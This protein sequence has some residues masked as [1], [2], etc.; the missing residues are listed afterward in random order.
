MLRKLF[1]NLIYFRKPVW[2]TGISLPELL[3]FIATHE[4]GRA[5]DLGCGTGTNVI[6]LAKSGWQVSGVDFAYKAISRARKKARENQ[7]KVDLQHDDVTR[8][9][10]VSGKFDLILDIGCF[11]ALP[12]GTYPKYISNVR[13]LLAPEG[14][15]LL[16]AFFK[17]D[18]VVPGPGLNA[19][20][21]EVL[22]RSFRLVD[23]KDGTDRGIRASAWLTFQNY[24]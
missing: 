23:R 5:L 18:S 14:T 12:E 7:V 16:Y 3:A 21:F 10:K 1:F 19:E 22:S 6:T 8:L 4:P 15:F 13:H 2:D 17:P 11:H 9:T 24:P 20:A